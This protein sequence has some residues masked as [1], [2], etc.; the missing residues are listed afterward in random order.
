MELNCQ[1]AGLLMLWIGQ[2]MLDNGL[3]AGAAIESGAE[4]HELLA[5]LI[6]YNI[7]EERACEIESNLQPHDLIDPFLFMNA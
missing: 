7:G 6:E 4:S 1:E 3:T 2:K 5:H